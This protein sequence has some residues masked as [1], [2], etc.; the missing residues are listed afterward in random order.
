[1]RQQFENNEF[2]E[3]EEISFGD[4]LYKFLPYWPFFVL[5]IILSLAGTWIYLR[6]KIPIYQTT[7]TLLIKDDKKG[8]AVDNPLEAF[9]LF[10]SQKNLENEIEVLQSKTLMQEVVKNLHLYAPVNTEGRV[11]NK[12]AYVLS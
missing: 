3:T 1:M 11:L 7:A 10:G 4:L 5:L 9:D 12:S 2:E 8:G 6:Y